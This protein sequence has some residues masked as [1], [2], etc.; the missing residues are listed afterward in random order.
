MAILKL[1][2]RYDMKE[3]KEYA[4]TSIERLYW[5]ADNNVHLLELAC[6]HRVDKW[7]KD[8]IKQ[9]VCCRL[10]SFTKEETEKIGVCTMLAIGKTR[11]AL[12]EHHKLLA[13][14]PY[15]VQH[16]NKCTGLNHNRCKEVYQEL[17]WK[18]VGKALIDPNVP[19]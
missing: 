4:Q 7:L 9:L 18:H 2:D 5:L 15:P 1:A 14:F 6:T 19:L 13:R 17:W 12:N 10:T 3:A 8:A 11:D 16:S